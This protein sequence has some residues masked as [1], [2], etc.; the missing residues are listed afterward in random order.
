MVSMPCSRE[1]TT[2]GKKCEVISSYMLHSVGGESSPSLSH[3]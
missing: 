2:I 1:D 3:V